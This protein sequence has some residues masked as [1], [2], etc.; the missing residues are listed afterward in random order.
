LRFR[1]KIINQKDYL[2]KNIAQ[3]GRIKIL[4]LTLKH[5][6]LKY[7]F[8]DLI[9]VP[10]RKNPNSINMFSKDD[11]KYLKRVIGN[12]QVILF[13][14]SGFSS[15]AKNRLLQPFPLGKE[16]GAILW[17]FLGYDGDYDG[18]SLS[19]MYQAFQAVG[20]KRDKK[21]EFLENHLLSG[22]IPESYSTITEPFWY[23]IY[24]INVDDILH[25]IYYK[26]GKRISELIYPFHEYEERDQSLNKTQII[27]LHGKLP[28]EPEQ[29]IF[30]TQQ[31]AK[32]QLA[33]QP[34]YSQFV[35]DYAT[36]PTIFV[37]TDLNEPIF[38]RYIEAREGRF[39]YRE[40]RPKSFLITKSLSPVKIDNLKNHYNVHYIKGS[41]SDFMNW[42]NSI[43][44]DLPSREDILRKTLPNLLNLYE[45]DQN[46]I[47]RRK[48]L[49]EF[50]KGFNKIPKDSTP[51]RER[52][53]FLLGA[54][55]RWNDILLEL[56]IPRSITRELISS[57]EKSIEQMDQNS[58]AK[59]FILTG[60]AGSGKSTILK[61]LGLSLAQ[62]GRTAFLSY[63]DYL[64]RIEDI[65]NTLEII[66]DQV[67]L[68][69]DNANNVV[70][71]L[72]N[73]LDSLRSLH[74]KQPII[75]L[76]IRSNNFDRLNY[77][78]DPDLVD[79]ERFN[80]PDLN[81]TEINHLIDKLDQN[82]LLGVLKGKSTTERFKEF[83][84]RAHRQILI[85]MKEATNGKSFNDIIESE[86]DSINP[87]EARI[88]ALCI[89]LNTELGYT[90]SKQDFI[91]FSKVS[92]LEALN[93]LETALNGTIIWVGNKDRF[94]LRH[95]ILAE[96]II[97]HCATLEMLKESYIRVLSILAPELKK[98]IGPSRKFNLYKSLINHQVL[99]H[100][101]K[102]DIEQAREVFDSITEYFNDDAHFWLQ[103]G[104]LEVEGIGGDLNL[105]ENYLNQAE[106]IAP[107][108]FY[109][110]NA[111]CNLYYK[112]SHI[113]SEY[114]QA[115]HY[116]ER[117]DLMAQNL[118][119]SVGKQEPHIYHIYCNGRYYFIKKWVQDPFYKK[120]E[121]SNLRRTILT[122]IKIH[123]RDKKL[124][125]IFQ[126]INRAYLNLGID[127]EMEDPDIP[128]N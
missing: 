52:S 30:S 12:N 128:E 36:L 33:H 69:L 19:E 124:D 108:Y 118:L 51:I 18:T 100:R 96:Y 62:N 78:L 27:Y 26:T 38:E 57:V 71:Q 2:R 17:S 42:I 5:F 84:Y 119:I 50:A 109:I 81:D 114:S 106:S 74:T 61:R 92:H 110:Q 8:S 47:Y 83:K 21:R 4:K 29:L 44:D 93:Y 73:L 79:I 103:Y 9:I 22:E 31:Y 75:I 98:S 24:T 120:I 43:K 121:L 32:S 115:L 56:D 11:E 102:E 39:G 72:P 99:Y 35:Y 82:N 15:E 20:I 80:I 53:A 25:N 37:G 6:L 95:K 107:D 40:L 125:I 65:I 101:F 77:Y 123:P 59:V 46:Q 14:G 64:P 55:P 70:S 49:E 97:K 113:Q 7:K 45:F 10:N 13:V 34:L 91:G 112:L 23:K 67:I 87:E 48:T 28:C 117:A 68:L 105:A 90:N 60:Y 58:K 63:S 41:V 104:S 126:A 94:M 1:L 85:A 88:L 16:L 76:S 54:S 116:K 122:A 3:Q 89:A 66:S 111:K 127:A 86:F